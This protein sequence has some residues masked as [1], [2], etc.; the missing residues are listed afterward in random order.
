M[1]HCRHGPSCHSCSMELSPRNI[2]ELQSM[3][4]R[5]LGSRSRES[6][7]DFDRY[8][9]SRDYGLT[10]L[11]TSKYSGQLICRECDRRETVSH[12]GQSLSSL[13][14]PC[15]DPNCA[16][17][18]N[19]EEDWRLNRRY[20]SSCVVAPLSLITGITGWVTLNIIV[21]CTA[22]LTSMAGEARVTCLAIVD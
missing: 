15:D 12:G 13:G 14:W 22:M 19:F 5:Y 8:S 21:L 3:L 18:D 4:G 11:R 10:S 1:G 16:Y 7:D 2:R 9:R 17:F 6:F 20:V